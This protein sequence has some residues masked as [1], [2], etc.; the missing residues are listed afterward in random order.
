MM[1]PLGR[2]DGCGFPIS[3][4]GI[5]LKTGRILT[6]NLTCSSGLLGFPAEPDFTW[7]RIRLQPQVV[8]IDAVAVRQRNHKEIAGLACLQTAAQVRAAERF[9]SVDGREP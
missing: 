4:S 5:L 2:T 8:G 6:K 3:S 1:A 7:G 9:R